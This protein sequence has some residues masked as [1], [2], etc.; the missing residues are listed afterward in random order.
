[1]ENEEGEEG[2]LSHCGLKHVRN[3]MKRGSCSDWW[4]SL[5]QSKSV[6][7]SDL[8]FVLNRLHVIEYFLISSTALFN[9]HQ[10]KKL[11]INLFEELKYFF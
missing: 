1:M 7:K 2:E 6:V 3:E 10:F 8:C 11:K 9:N 4:N 5:A